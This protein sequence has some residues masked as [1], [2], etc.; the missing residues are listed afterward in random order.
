M[1]DYLVYIQSDEYPYGEYAENAELTDEEAER[2]RETLRADESYSTVD[3]DLAVQR[4]ATVGYDQ[5]LRAIR[6]ALGWTE[7]EELADERP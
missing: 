6:D 7:E 1:G 5:T 3:I 2:L 4:T